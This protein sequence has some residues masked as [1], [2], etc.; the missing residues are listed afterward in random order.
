MGSTRQE[1]LRPPLLRDVAVIGAGPAGLIAA[2]ALA[3]AGHDVVVLEEH[4]FEVCAAEVSYYQSH[5]FG[6]FVPLYL[7]SVLWELVLM[8]FRARDSAATLL[9]VARRRP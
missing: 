5:Y 7:A 1:V 2:R 4:G 9:F 3:S 8:A 6:F